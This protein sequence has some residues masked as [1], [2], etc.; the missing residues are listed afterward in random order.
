M[1]HNHVGRPFEHG[2]RRE[3]S[4]EQKKA[5]GSFLAYKRARLHPSELGLPTEKRRTPGLRREEVAFLSGVSV[6]WYTWLEQGRDIKASP[7]ALRRIAD[8]L[9]LDRTEASH[10]FVLS[11]REPPRFETDGE[12]S[13]GLT[14]LV[15]A[16]DPLPAYIR[17]GRLDVLAWNAPVADLLVDYA[18]LRP[19]ER[20][21]LRLLFT[22]PDYRTLI[23][24]WEQMAR[25]MIATFRAARARAQD[26]APFDR[27]AEELRDASP[28][29]AAWW[30]EVEVRAFTE[31]TKRLQHPRLGRVDLTYVAL[32]PEGRPDLSLT[33]Y[34][35]GNEGAVAAPQALA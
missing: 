16:L 35:R 8:V 23:V 9:R 2:A 15:K 14:M 7:D 26:Q 24:D 10:L 29:F 19:H 5:L 4:V 28:E 33:V 22:H 6:S 21:T 25:S 32:A 13:D 18:S 20:N 27:L 11:S 30:P 31:G 12:P 1:K 3:A 17:N 34:M